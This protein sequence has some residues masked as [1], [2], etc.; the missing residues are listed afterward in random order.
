MTKLKFALLSAG[1]IVDKDSNNL[2][3]LNQIDEVSSTFVPAIFPEL[4]LVACFQQDNPTDDEIDTE[5]ELI[6]PSGK[7]TPVI[8][9]T[10]G[11]RGKRRARLLAKLAGF[12]IHEFGRNV[13]K[14]NW[15][16]RQA[17]VSGEFEIDLDA[18]RQTKPA[19]PVFKK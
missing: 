13:F 16:A 10:I 5:F 4:Y 7:K 17:G 3:I 8:K 6:A 11:F 18:N 19:T 2:S 15:K 1:A 14:L 9:A 12:P